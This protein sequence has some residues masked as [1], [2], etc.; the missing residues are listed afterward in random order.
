M[1]ETIQPSIYSQAN[2]LLAQTRPWQHQ[3]EDQWEHCH[4]SPR[5]RKVSS[6]LR[7]V[8]QP[9]L[10][11]FFQP[12]RVHRVAWRIRRAHSRAFRSEKRENSKCWE[13]MLDP[14]INSKAKKNN[15]ARIKREG[16]L[17]THQ[18]WRRLATR[19]ESSTAVPDHERDIQRRSL[20]LQSRSVHKDLQSNPHHQS[21]WVLWMGSWHWANEEHDQQR[22][23]K[24]R[25]LR[26]RPQRN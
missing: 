21:T 4:P 25:S 6:V 3:P 1:A 23:H 24:G 14:G 13:D 18:G 22:A 11:R 9:R 2:Q 10:Q 7:M 12:I 15:S 26:E 17:L 20:L 16:L 19:S 5:V 8:R